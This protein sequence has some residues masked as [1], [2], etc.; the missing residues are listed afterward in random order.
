MPPRWYN[1][2]LLLLSSLACLFSVA[3]TLLNAQDPPPPLEPVVV[4][5]PEGTPEF[6]PLFPG[7]GLA[8]WTPEA[9]ASFV[10]HD[11]MIASEGK[12]DYP[13][14]LR[15]NDIYENFILRFEFKTGNYG[16]G[17][18]FLHA[19]RHGRNSRVGF[20]IQLSDDVR[21]PGPVV[22]STGAIYG[23]VPPL[24]QAAKPLGEW[25]QVEV[26][27][28][29]PQ[30]KVILNG[31][32]VQDLNVEENPDLKYRLRS[33]YLGLQDRGKQIVFRNLEIKALPGKEKWITLFDGKSFDGWSVL[34][35]EGAQWKREEGDLVA[36]DGNGYLV[37]EQEWQDF[38]LQTY[39]KSSPLANGGIF[40]RWKSL[41]PK[42]RGNEIQI[43]DIPDSN[44]P[45]GSVYDLAYASKFPITPGEWYLMQIRV[46]GPRAVIRVN[47]ETVA[48]TD[49]LNV[50]RAGHIALQMHKRDAWVRFQDIKLKVLPE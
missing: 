49:Q 14:W 9:G 34:Q 15:S 35:P 20:E 44:N 4:A 31:E 25:N 28:D 24:K 39:V 30:L 21:D 3:D 22:I 46:E 32:V 2:L 23:S 42:D 47:G 11:G 26:M 13:A 19:P 10:N 7:E 48:E 17:G 16:E 50:I 33:G 12:A 29:W 8:G 27:F 45:T 5:Q 1:R 40:F 43:E 36:T 37:S 38:E 6:K 41:V 18:I